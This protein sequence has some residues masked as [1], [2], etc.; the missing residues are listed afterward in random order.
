MAMRLVHRLS[1]GVP[2]LINVICDRALLGAYAH[3]RRRVTVATV[4]R[5]GAEVREDLVDHR[6]LGDEGDDAHRAVAGRTP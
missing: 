6:R 1:G 4:R 2:R 3:N 5:A